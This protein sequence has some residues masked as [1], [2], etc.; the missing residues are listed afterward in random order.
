MTTLEEKTTR[1]LTGRPGFTESR[2][3]DVKDLL[4][5]AGADKVTELTEDKRAAFDRL[6]E[7]LASRPEP[8]TTRERAEAEATI[9]RAPTAKADNSTYELDPIALQAAITAYHNADSDYHNDDS[10]YPL[11]GA[12]E[13]YFTVAMARGLPLP[14]K[15]IPGGVEGY[16]PLAEILKEAY[17]QSARGKGKERYANGKPFLMQ[18]IMSI[19]RMVG[20]G[21][22]LGQ[23]M[24]K[25]QEA[26]GMYARSNTPAA[27]AE[28]LGVIVYTA[29]AI[30]LMKEQENR[31]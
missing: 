30:M 19:G 31:L 15:V 7:Q 11:H 16:A 14:M 6:L 21:Y 25:A 23:A 24:K 29:A 28:L 4:A 2:K 20:P 1:Y 9:H 26:G 17:D 8:M 12:I 10:D 3:V 27:V 13:T 18:P 5:L 22:P